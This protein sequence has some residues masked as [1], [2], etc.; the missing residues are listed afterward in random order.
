MNRLVIIG[1]LTRDPETHETNNGKSVCNFTLAVNRRQKSQ[2]SDH[3]EADFFRVAAWG[4]MGESCQKY[5][6]KGRKV[7]VTGAVSVST[8]TAQDGTTRAQMEIKYA[9]DV[10]FL[11][12][13]QDG[14]DAENS[15][16]AHATTA[17]TSAASA[18][19]PVDSDDLP[20]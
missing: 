9:E 3:P 15:E 7:A 4:A 16:P 6:T 13:R 1:N 12:S 5:L 18:A 20:F 10:E 8:Y 11:S 19:I 2:N 17:A 14:N